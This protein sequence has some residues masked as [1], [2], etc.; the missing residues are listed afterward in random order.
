M[1]TNESNL[2]AV[3][4]ENFESEVISAS[5]SQPV[6]VDFWA[7]WCGPCRMITPMLDEVAAS[8]EG[9]ARVVQVN[10][11]EQSDLASAF[12]VRAI[13]TLLIFRYGQIASRIVGLTAKDEIL[14]KLDAAQN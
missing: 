12:K 10:V 2:V 3:T 4:A 9:V 5:R 1:K 14:A 7:E 8:R 11:D 13:P 6:L